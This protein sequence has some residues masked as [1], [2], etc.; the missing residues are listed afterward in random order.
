MEEVIKVAS[1][2]CQRYQK[3][4][5]CRIDEMKLHK[6]L[7]FIQRECIAQTGEQ[8]F[9]DKFEAW[10]YGPVMVCVRQHYKD[11]SLHEQM[12]EEVIARYKSVFD[13]VFETLA[14]KD[15]WSLSTL[16]HGEYSWQNARIGYD[17]D[18]HCSV[19]IDPEDIRKDAE[20]IKVRRFMLRHFVKK[21]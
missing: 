18:A 16:T 10:K 19:E 15:A 4:F 17:K 2:V 9:P 12:R 6:L 21:S 5:R 13:K 11:D 20:R 8:M 3:E 14:Y 7:Y 1:Y